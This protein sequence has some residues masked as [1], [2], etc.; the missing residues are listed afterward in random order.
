MVR[1]AMSKDMRRT[2]DGARAAKAGRRH[3][4]MPATLA[5]ARNGGSAGC[6]SNA[7]PSN[8]FRMSGPPRLARAPDGPNRGK[9]GGKSAAGPWYRWRPASRVGRRPA[10]GMPREAAAV[11]SQ[12]SFGDDE[13]EQ[14]CKRQR[15]RC[16][17]ARRNDGVDRSGSR[18]GCVTSP[19]SASRQP[20]RSERGPFRRR[21]RL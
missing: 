10:L 7:R 5:N 16:Q 20:P 4:P 3:F 15:G 8:S 17:I 2:A 19:S 1:F 21:P 18:D 6:G 13:N 9:S 11:P 14:P 12:V